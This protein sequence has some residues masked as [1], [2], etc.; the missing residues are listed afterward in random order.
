MPQASP[1]TSS[2]DLSAPTPV[3][4]ALSGGGRQA[5]WVHVAGELDLLTSPELAG[6]LAEARVEALLTVVDAR[7]LTFIDSCGVHAIHDASR[8]CELDGGRLMLIP[9]AAVER[10]LNVAGL[11]EGISTFDLSP[12]EPAPA[13]HLVNATAG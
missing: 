7:E 8:A 2:A 10:I 1:V 12:D 11:R 13:L 9:S 5:A 6:V 4:C 3:Q